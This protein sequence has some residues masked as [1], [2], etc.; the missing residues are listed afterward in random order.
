M[1]VVIP[2]RGGSKRIP[3]KALK[4]LGQRTLLQWAINRAQA[5]GLA[6]V[7]ASEDDAI[8]QKAKDLGA[9]L[10]VRDSSTATDGAPDYAWARELPGRYPE[11]GTF[12]ILRITSP[13]LGQSHIHLAH[14]R[15][16]DGRYTSVRCVT[17][18]PCHP[19]KMWTVDARGIGHPVMRGHREDGTPYHSAPTQTLPQV[20]L[21]TAGLEIT[22]R[23][24][25][26]RTL[27][28]GKVGLYEVYGPAALDLNTLDD[29][30]KAEEIAQTWTF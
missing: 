4:L 15:L 1:L 18:A 9:D 13:F 27:A 10:F 6:F 5:S 2:A 25:L 7:V 22:T 11:H 28:G 23:D 12:A 20:Y 8:L 24:T 17:A 29:W 16:V 26:R 19:A 21:Q 14:K 30:A 3:N